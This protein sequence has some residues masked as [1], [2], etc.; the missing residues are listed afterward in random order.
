MDTNILIKI[1][2][3]IDNK[4]ENQTYKEKRQVLG[5]LSGQIIDLPDRTIY[6]YSASELCSMLDRKSNIIENL[7]KQGVVD[8]EGYKQYLLSENPRFTPK[9]DLNCL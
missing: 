4:L 9:L 2:D 7:Y 5:K 3:D 1:L 8:D 6:R